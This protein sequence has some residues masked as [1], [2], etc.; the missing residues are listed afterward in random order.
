MSDPD[1][2][3][4]DAI[5]WARS[6][7]HTDAAKTDPARRSAAKFIL[8][9]APKVTM[10]EIAWNDDAYHLMGAYLDDGSEKVMLYPVDHYNRIACADEAI[11]PSLLTPNGRRYEITEVVDEVHPRELSTGR[12][13]DEAPQGTV[14]TVNN[15]MYMRLVGELWCNSR[16]DDYQDFSDMVELGP[17][18]VLVW[19]HEL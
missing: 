12:E 8:A 9:H 7:I 11:P 1:V 10:D 14:V 16:D 17:C 15:T 4:Y 18:R 19:G 6:F 3:D 2:P 13:F 5:E